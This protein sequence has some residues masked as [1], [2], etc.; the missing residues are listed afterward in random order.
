MKTQQWLTSILSG[1]ISSIVITQP[2]KIVC[3]AIF[4]AFFCRHWNDVKEESEYLD[5]DRIEITDE[6]E[7][8][9]RRLT[10]LLHISQSSKSINRLT[11]G[12]LAYAREQRLKEIQMWSIIRQ[13]FVYSLFFILI[14]LMTFS[15]RQQTNF[16]Q[17]RHLRN[18]FFNTRQIDQDYTQV[19]D[20]L[21]RS[22]VNNRLFRS[23][24]LMN[25]GH[26]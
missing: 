9:P 17:V 5:D 7:N 20:V 26:G 10:D 1:I 21:F 14:S 8:N 19:R 22:C 2:I 15:S 3:F 6:E 13:F 25:I 4:F 23:E 24:R 12:E 18:Y 11:E 16:Y